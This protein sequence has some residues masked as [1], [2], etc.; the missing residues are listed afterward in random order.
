MIKLIREGS[1]KYPWI[2]IT[3]MLMIVVAFIVG[4]GWWG[5]GDAQTDTVAEVGEL[6]VSIEE[7]RRTYRNLYDYYKENMGEEVKD[8]EVKQAALESLVNTK[9]WVQAAERMGLTITPEE[10]RAQ[11]IGVQ[12][13]HKD[14]RFHPQ[15]YRTVLL[16][17]RL[18][19]ALFEALERERLLAEK[20]RTMV[21]ESVAL[22]P[23]ERQEAETLV[24]TVAGVGSS[25]PMAKDLLLQNF[26][27]QKQQRALNAYTEA[28]KTKMPVE[29]YRENM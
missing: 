10:L 5:Y 25:T 8:D 17:N 9:L 11:V 6:S 22:T 1:R 20:A 7:Y 3:L 14:G 12:A 28:L 24:G 2:L 18:T 27:F 13:F 21:V 19:P 29:I 16:R 4:M 26:L 15:V 23:A